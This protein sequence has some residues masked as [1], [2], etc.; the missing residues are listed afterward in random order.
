[1]LVVSASREEIHSSSNKTLLFIISENAKV[2]AK[3]ILSLS[4][5]DKYDK[6][7]LIYL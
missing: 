7:P 3:F 2:K 5:P 1:M 6:S 4:P